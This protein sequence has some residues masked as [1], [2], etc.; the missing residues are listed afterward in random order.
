MFLE[1]IKIENNNS[2]VR[3]IQFH[4]GLN[5]I[6]DRTDTKNKQKSGN[7]VGK[8]TVLRLVD[9]CFNG[10]KRKIY[11][12]SEFRNKENTT[13]KDFL[14]NNNIVITTTLTDDLSN[15]ESKKLEIQ[16]NF[17]TYSDKVL[18]INGEDIPTK[19]FENVLK[20]RI[21]SFSGDK[22]TFRQIINKYIRD[23]SEKL[24]NTIK[25]LHQT[26]TYEE[27][28]ALY[29][30]WL[31]IDTDE[32][33][34]KQ[35]LY[36]NKISEERLLGR[37]TEDRSKSEIN[38]SLKVID[39]DISKLNK[40]KETFN[41]NEEYEEDL[42][43][44]NEL[45]RKINRISS[46]I[47]QLDLKKELIEESLDNLR[48]E[49]SD[50]DTDQLR[51]LYKSAN[52]F[53]PDLDKQF[54]ELVGFHNR[55]I[56]NRID[57]ISDEIPN[58]DESRTSLEDE[59]SGLIR[60]ENS[61]AGKLN[62]SGALEELELLINQLNDRF[63][64][65]GAYEEQLSQITSTEESL[66]E[67]NA[68]FNKINTE[69]ASL[70]DEIEKRITE[71]NKYFSDF[72]KRL[73]GEQFVLSSDH[74]DRAYQLKISNIEGNPG[75]GKKKGQI[76]AFDLAHIQYCDNN[77]LPTLH[78]VMHDQLENI[79]GNQLETISNI[80]NN[81]NAQFIA[82]ILRDKLPE[83]INIEEHVV[84][85]LSQDEKLFKV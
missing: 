75:T 12:D 16:R 50:I 36:H 10:D 72:S 38:Q 57:F 64:L 31:G 73:Y 33:A 83:G 28:E 59:L 14:L 17:L 4:K 82:P 67:I 74:N 55:M 13:V 11:E 76:V 47:S 52:N 43:S 44:L 3:D 41:L 37:L 15:S 53:I 32:I 22:P 46:N 20:R 79:H 6:L 8:T 23:S 2:L 60:Q 24:T 26:T 25:V 77:N 48:S 1:S 21:F 18:R 84:L 54:E 5:L 63:E 45:K 30:F 29:F 7:S 70:N 85:S 62:K 78:F 56:A 69:I 71:F 19:D 40:K 80:S 66:R 58:L 49:K 65:K 61:L 81:I 27:Y 42:E 9:F 39:R 68:E 51:E 35:E 34:R